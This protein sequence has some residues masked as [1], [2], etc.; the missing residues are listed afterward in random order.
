MTR[1]IT[2]LSRSLQDWSRRHH[3][4]RRRSTFVPLV[5]VP[6]PRLIRSHGAGGPRA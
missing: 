5:T 1:T 3:R 4:P 6:A 2:A